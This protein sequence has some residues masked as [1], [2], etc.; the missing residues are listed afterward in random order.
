MTSLILLLCTVFVT[1][2]AQNSVTH[3]SGKDLNERRAAQ[4]KATKAAK[5]TLK[6]IYPIAQIAPES[7][8]ETKNNAVDLRTPANIVT[9]TIYNEKDGRYSIGTRLGEG[10]LITT[11]ILLNEMEY[12]KWRIERSMQNYFRKRIDE[13][14]AEAE[15]KNKFDFT[16]MQF[17]L[18][19]AEK[20]F[21]P[22]RC[23][24]KDT[25]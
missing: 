3:S 6:P 1:L 25:G 11:P 22:R 5:D 18:G 13:D 2:T 24:N 17:D 7:I 8:E 20:I 15:G 4:R 14:W 19:P 16:D 12:T 9:D 10:K 23:E 21:G